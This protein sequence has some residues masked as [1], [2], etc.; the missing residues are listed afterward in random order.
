MKLPG[1]RRYLAQSLGYDIERVQSFQGLVGSQVLSSPIFKENA[2]C[3][4]ICYGLALQGLGKPGLHT[5]L[6][7][8]EIVKDRLIKR[9]KP[10]A[11]AAA[12]L[13]L[14]GCGISFGAY[15]LAMNSV[16]A[17]SWKSATEQADRSR[18]RKQP[19]KSP[20]PMRPRAVS[21]P[22]TR[23]ASIWWETWKGGSGGWN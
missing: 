16:D 19:V 6:L 22:P 4:G 14:L 3:F 23:S 9:K 8:K 5:N 1:L 7:P 18:Q 15:A 11:V 21:N 20:R 12:A 10:W 13:L 2:I 17:S